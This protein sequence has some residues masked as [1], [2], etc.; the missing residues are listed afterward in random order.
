MPLFF[1]Y[2]SFGMYLYPIILDN[3]YKL[4]ELGLHL[5]KNIF[6]FLYNI[7]KY[8]YICSVKGNDYGTYKL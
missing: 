4:T 8:N 3:N 1:F 6:N 5:L 7:K 2:D